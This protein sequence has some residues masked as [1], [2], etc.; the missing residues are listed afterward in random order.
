MVEPRRPSKAA[1]A[2]QLVAKL[3]V[4]GGAADVLERLVQ[5]L[6]SV[7]TA[8]DRQGS[9]LLAMAS[10]LGNAVAV[11]VLLAH[12]AD[13]S[14]GTLEKG[15][16]PLFWA[17]AQGH[18]DV[19]QLLLDANADPAQRNQGG[20]TPVLWACRSGTT[21]VVELLLQHE[22]SVQRCANMSGMTPLMCA[23]AG[24]HTAV[25]QLLLASS[26][27][28]RALDAVDEH[29]R[30]ALHFAAATAAASSSP[31][32]VQALLDAGADWRIRAKDGLT[33]LLEARAGKNAEA[34]RLLTLTWQQQQ[35]PPPPPSRSSKPPPPPA[36]RD[37]PSRGV[38]QPATSGQQQRD[39][40]SADSDTDEAEA[41]EKEARAAEAT[42]ATPT[43]ETREA[44]AAG[45]LE[46]AVSTSQS[47]GGEWLLAA[48]RRRRGGRKRPIQ[49]AAHPPVAAGS[50]AAAEQP[51][52]PP[53]AS[54]PTGRTD[55]PPPSSPSASAAAAWAAAPTDVPHTGSGAAT[56]PEGAE[57]RSPPG[58]TAVAGDGVERPDDAAKLDA[59]SDGAPA[60]AAFARRHPHTAALNLQ[61]RHVLGEGLHE[62]SMAQLS[63]LQEAQWQLQRQLEEARMQLARRQERDAVEARLAL[64][65]ER[66]LA[67]QMAT[68]ELRGGAG[69]CVAASISTET[70]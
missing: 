21:A 15:N 33:A 48:P 38:A 70:T 29:G 22:P 40:A 20:D 4:E 68:F 14:K 3:V 7:D 45:P 59:V 37:H 19:A 46:A 67:R 42:Q 28:L 10:K 32:S 2:A 39:S 11:R 65:I 47:G 62:L 44:E 25:L 24:A 64:E 51:T 26:E 17:A 13:P 58:R 30:T 69:G 27:S 57:G 53:P 6:D 5:S 56:P 34:E 36:P 66:A 23:G 18:A 31:E 1:V 35:E 54:G 63:A 60:W 43:A 8:I 55:A 52:D 9:T 50:P 12:R 49:P 16:T 61:L 41:S